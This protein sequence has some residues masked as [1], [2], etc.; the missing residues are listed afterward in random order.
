MESESETSKSTPKKH[1]P[2]AKNLH[3]ALKKL[4]ESNKKGTEKLSVEVTP[5]S[6]SGRSRRNV[7]TPNWADIISGRKSFRDG[8]VLRKD[9]EISDEEEVEKDDIAEETELAAA[10]IAKTKK[11]Q[12]RK[13]KSKPED[14]RTKIDD[15]E[16]DTEIPKEHDDKESK[17]CNEKEIKHDKTTE[18]VKET[19][20]ND[21]EVDGAQSE[22]EEIQHVTYVV[23]QQKKAKVVPLTVMKGT[24]QCSICSKAFS[25]K[26]LLDQHINF[27]HI[28]SEKGKKI[29][30]ED[31]D[32]DD[33][34][35]DDIVEI[36]ISDFEAKANNDSDSQD[37]DFNEIEQNADDI[38][39]ADTDIK[40]EVR[41]EIRNEIK[42][43]RIEKIRSFGQLPSKRNAN[44]GSVKCEKCGTKFAA[45]ANLKRHML[46]HTDKVYECPYCAKIMKRMDYVVAHVRK[47]HKEVDLEENP[48]D[49]EKYSHTVPEERDSDRPNMQSD[50]EDGKR[51]KMKVITG[52]GKKV[53]PECSKL[54]DTQE[55]LEQHMVQV[56][57]KEL[58]DAAYTCQACKKTFTSLVSFQVHKL[59]HR[60]KDF[61]CP[62]CDKKFT[63]NTQLQI[64]KRNDHEIQYGA[65]NYF[66]YLMNNGRI[67]CEICSANFDGV[68]EYLIHRHEHLTFEYLC[69]KC[70]NGFND[71][72]M[73]EKHRQNNCEGEEFHHFPC[74]VCNKRFGMYDARRKHVMTFHPKKS[75][76]FCHHCGKEFDNADLL[77]K[78]FESHQLERVYIC[79]TCDKTFFEKRNLIDHRDVHKSSKNFQCKIC[80]KFYLSYKSLQRHIKL[81]LANATKA[82]KYCDGK[83]ANVDDLN[84]HMQDEHSV[85]LEV[86]EFACPKCPRTYSSQV[87]LEKHYVLHE[88]D[89]GDSTKYMCTHCEQIFDSVEMPLEL[90]MEQEHP[91]IGREHFSKKTWKCS[92]CDFTTPHK[93]RIE[94]HMETHNAE[95]K[96]ECKYCGKRY[97][98][99]STLMTHIIS[100]RGK[101]RRNA[102]PQPICVWPDCGKQFM[103]HSLYK[104]HLIS[105]LY[106]VKSGKELCR[107]GQCAYS[108]MGGKKFNMVFP[109]GK[110]E[111]VNIQAIGF[112]DDMG[113]T[114]VTQ[115]M[116]KILTAHGGSMVEVNVKQGMEPYQSM[117]VLQ[118][119][120]AKIEDIE[121]HTE[122]NMEEEQIDLQPT[123]PTEEVTEGA[124]LF[125]E[126]PEASTS[127]VGT[128]FSTAVQMPAN[129]SVI[130]A[131][132]GAEGNGADS[133]A[134]MSTDG[135]KILYV[136]NTST[137][138][139]QIMEMPQSGAFDSDLMS[140]AN[141]TGG[142]HVII[143]G[144]DGR[145]TIVNILNMPLNQDGQGVSSQTTE[146]EGVLQSHYEC[147]VCELIFQ[148]ACHC[149]I[150]L[151]KYA[152]GAEFSQV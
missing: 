89:G 78:H 58:K 17:E 121:R 118:E 80:L 129:S 117:E 15:P 126:D 150:P 103:K 60:K 96:F 56:H 81:H 30:N 147:G 141:T 33:D 140:T 24:Y 83:F 64:H 72:E 32:E 16:E 85:A 87:K 144:S 84:K 39:D 18:S 131:G 2:A 113:Q 139:L 50:Q 9:G 69:A 3:S 152:R 37:E 100:H 13:L 63:S 41:K 114:H 105:H 110:G 28:L 98:T 88:L 70:G 95:K 93:Q 22:N 106:K 21:K 68:D 130:M 59:T 62:H 92:E 8:A 36:K 112:V 66:G 148:H 145:Q 90:H 143:E 138:E 101:V 94:R 136:N 76:Y 77:A 142:E 52:T 40:R 1:Q 29:E 149:T 102:K 34:F 54:F 124:D 5:V 128:P 31:G 6:V 19:E 109:P 38:N 51:D 133:D 104:R 151:R 99:T 120:I 53:C 12:Q 134:S 49:F 137:K 26:T 23:K 27:L 35:A 55:E 71:R 11:K 132:S 42:A 119:A 67:T 20:N 43:A 82:C 122:T 91:N 108:G 25:S 14:N 57:D 146:T 48:I 123:K 79:E 44:S 127:G 135:Q 116:N 107:C 75:D 111:S 65:L 97:Q 115:H 4:P 46:L 47:V 73:F 86:E 74:G 125:P 7:S 61:V 45:L 10:S